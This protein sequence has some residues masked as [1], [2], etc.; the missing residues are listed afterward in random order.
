LAEARGPIWRNAFGKASPSRV[1]AGFEPITEEDMTD[2]HTAAL[3]GAAVDILDFPIARAGGCPFDPPRALRTLQAQA[4]VAKVRLWDGST[5][6][7]ITRHADQ[8]NLLADERISH[9]GSLP[10]FPEISAGGRARG[11]RSRTFIRMDDP[12]HDRLRRMVTHPFA[13]KRVE[14]LRPG[15]QRI[16]DALIDAMLAG[17][18]PIDLVQAF[19][20]PVPSLVICRLLGVP[21]ADHHFFQRKAALMLRRDTPV[22][23]QLMAQAELMGYLTDLATDKLAQPGDDLL[24]SLALEQVRSG[25]LS[26]VELASTGVLLLTA[27]HET[28]TNMIAL[29]TLALL[30]HPDQLAA[31]RY[32]DDPEL[33]AQAVEELL[34]Y[35]TIVQTG[36]RRLALAD[37]EIGGHVIRAGD[38]VIFPVDVGNRDEHMFADPDELDLRRN[39]RGHLAFGFGVHR[40]LGQPLARM[41][42]QV[43]YGTLYRRIPTLRLAVDLDEVPFK[44]DSAV[45]GVYELPVSW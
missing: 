33:I 34:R 25:S 40:C 43:V 8:R 24:S 5:P 16:V 22:D 23:E 45:Y 12:E 21:Y 11:A 26:P 20:L 18:K 2:T 9:D 42:L 44:H 37:I 31:L 14:A 7:L 36:L 29:G 15:V 3:G 30:Q 28:T 4:P 19:A 6:W 35:L 27:G 39:A 38:S 41:E 1:L 32:T 13:I 10:G 17:P